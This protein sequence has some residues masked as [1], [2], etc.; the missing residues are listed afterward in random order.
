MPKRLTTEEVVEQFKKVHGDKYDY[1]KV[2]YTINSNKVEIVCLDHGSFFQLP[3]CHKQ[4]K[5]CRECGSKI[6]AEKVKFTQEEALERCIARGGDHYLYDNM[7]YISAKEKIEIFCTIHK[8]YFWQKYDSHVS[9][10]R[11]CKKCADERTGNSSRF[12]QEEAMELCI[13]RDV[14][15]KYNYDKMTY[16]T[17]RNKIKIYCKEHKG[18]FWQTFYDHVNAKYDCQSCSSSGFDKNKPAI[19][20]YL[21][22]VNGNDH[23]YKIGITNRTVE[24]RFKSLGLE[25][26][27]VLKTWEYENGAD[28]IKDET[29]IKRHYKEHQWTGDDLLGNGNTELFKVDILGLDS[30]ALQLI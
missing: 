30:D 18:Y 13:S 20:Y 4:G 11:G 7:I 8:E 17:A 27:A 29:N 14:D 9:S 2:K 1:S 19:M 6:T 28:A 12:T 16:I 23:A 22:V 25:N 24:E 10:L 26:I 3:T 15:N 5:G 21:L